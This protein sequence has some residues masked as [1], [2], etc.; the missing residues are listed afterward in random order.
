[1]ANPR[2]DM[3][4]FKLSCMGD[5]DDDNLCFLDNFLDEH[6][7]LSARAAL[8]R[9]FG[10]DY[11]KDAKLFMNRENPGIKLSPLLGNSRNMI[12]GSRD[13]KEALEKH[14]TNQIEY[15]PF[16]LYDH[17]KRVHSRDYFIINPIGTFDCLDFK[18]SVIK[19]D[20]EAPD[21]IISIHKTVLDRKKMKDAPQFFRIDRAPTAYVVGLEVA[22]EF[23]ARNFSNIFWAE[24]PL[25]SGK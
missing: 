20:D 8:G 17:R 2:K 24:L 6:E 1:M 7:G 10:K 16:T 11:P 23:K 25:S 15:L 4:F 19:W 21:E 3:R 13:F 9:R 22:R 14:C 12:V 18:E 5:P